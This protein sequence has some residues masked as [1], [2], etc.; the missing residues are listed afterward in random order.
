MLSAGPQVSEIEDI[1]AAVAEI[2]AGLTGVKGQDALQQRLDDLDRKSG[3]LE[4]YGLSMV[5][6]QREVAA[7]KHS[8]ET[9]Q[10]PKK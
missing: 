5:E 9:D 7:L 1:Q 3:N 2:K 4:L 6:L 10:K 8:I